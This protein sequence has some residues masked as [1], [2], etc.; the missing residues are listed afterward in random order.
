MRMVLWEE[1]VVGNVSLI[2]EGRERYIRAERVRGVVDV[3]SIY[4]GMS[5]ADEPDERVDQVVIG[6][7]V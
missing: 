7:D 5:L 6:I 4:K 1:G 3:D 2:L